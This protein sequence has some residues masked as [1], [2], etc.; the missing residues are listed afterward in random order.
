MVTFL[1]LCFSSLLILLIPDNAYA[2]GP[3]THLYYGVEVLRD[4]S[5]LPPYVASI[6]AQFPYD[7]LYGCISADITVGKK[8]THYRNHCHNWNVGFRILKEAHST[9][10]KAFALGYLGHLAADTVA[11]NFF[12]PSQIISSY[13]S[14][15]LGHTYWEVR[16]DSLIGP[17]YWQEGGKISKSVQ[18]EHDQLIRGIVERT[19]FP[20]EIN[21]TI[22]N[23]ILMIHRFTHWRRMVQ[24]I[25]SRSRWSLG[26]EDIEKYHRLSKLGILDFL[27]S[28]KDAECYRLDPTGRANFKSARQIRKSL[29][30]IAPGRRLPASTY[31]AVVRQLPVQA[32]P[33]D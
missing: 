15:S 4:M 13:S 2:W 32:P 21:K 31:R 26:L 19:L 18:K 9:S 16:A 10:Q 28:L 23:S 29:R 1:V 8:Y 22:F 25:G 5:V 24:A 30:R 3:A 12:V 11:H 6:L 20:F 14:K 27:I 17:E 7:F 33:L